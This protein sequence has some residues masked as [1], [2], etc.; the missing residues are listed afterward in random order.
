MAK[1]VGY[2][3]RIFQN[4]MNSITKGRQMDSRAKLVGQD[5]LGNKYFEIPA[6]PRYVTLPS[7]M[8]SLLF[9]SHTYM[10]L[11]VVAAIE[12][13]TLNILE[14]SQKIFN[15]HTESK[16]PLKHQTTANKLKNMKMIDLK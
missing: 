5:F 14:T 7:S 11:W 16:W 2:M 3:T 13:A 12:N 6:D 4:F 1:R 15:G 10:K 9:V 8:K